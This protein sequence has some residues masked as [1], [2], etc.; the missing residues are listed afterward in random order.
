MPGRE[1]TGLKKVHDPEL[2]NKWLN[3]R[4]GLSA[5]LGV[6][7]VLAAAHLRGNEKREY[8]SYY[9]SI[10]QALGQMERFQQDP[11]TLLIEL[12]EHRTITRMI[13]AA[14]S[15]TGYPVLQEGE[16][17]LRFGVIGVEDKPRIIIPSFVDDIR[18]YRIKGSQLFLYEEIDLQVSG[19]RRTISSLVGRANALIFYQS[20]EPDR[21]LRILSNYEL[22]SQAMSER[23][24]KYNP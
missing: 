3:W 10:N 2:E 19:A 22:G 9:R 1:P 12:P 7:G 11:V 17:L 16:E 5:V 23:G 14:A 13:A 18:A 21:A 20:P 15:T 4:V 8:G 24:I 6:A